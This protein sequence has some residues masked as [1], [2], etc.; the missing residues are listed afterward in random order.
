MVANKFVEGVC[1]SPKILVVEVVVESAGG[2]MFPKRLLL[3][4]VEELDVFTPKDNGGT[5]FASSTG[6]FCAP[7]SDPLPDTGVIVELPKRGFVL[8]T[9]GAGTVAA[10]FIAAA[11]VFSVPNTLDFAP[12]FCAVSVLEV[13][14]LLLGLV[15]SMD[16]VVAGVGKTGAAGTEEI[17]SKG[18]EIFPKSDPTVFAGAVSFVEK[19][20]IG[21]D[22]LSL[23]NPE[24]LDAVENSDVAAGAGSVGFEL[25]NPNNG[26]VV[27]LAVTPN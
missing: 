24:A 13:P 2:L 11:S 5:D 6:G 18:F 23:K 26:L 17:E 4:S 10:G 22:E 21:I 14:K 9:N 7:K 16:D 20:E 25:P 3:G 19:V 12:S 1:A 8:V 15:E 27:E